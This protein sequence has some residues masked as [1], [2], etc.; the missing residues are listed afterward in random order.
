MKN[1]NNKKNNQKAFEEEKRFE[2]PAFL[3][4]YK[5]NK[6][7]VKNILKDKLYFDR[8]GLYKINDTVCHGEYLATVAGFTGDNISVEK[9]KY[10]FVCGVMMKSYFDNLCALE[11]IEREWKS[12]L[13]SVVPI[14]LSR[15]SVH[16]TPLS[17]TNAITKIE[18]ISM[19]KS[20][21][22]GGAIESSNR[23]SP[24]F[25]FSRDEYSLTDGFITYFSNYSGKREYIQD[26]L[27][28]ELDKKIL[29]EIL[30]S[31][32]IYELIYEIV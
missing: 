13:Y 24:F 15:F 30:N 32:E 1:Y 8:D 21:N 2:K 10:W 7:V 31:V 19:Y 29:D 16:E 3:T 28:I 26:K 5:C 18:G 11:Y 17:F 22:K 25:T 12:N 23:F 20:D 4:G 9:R 27:S 6:I 14:Y